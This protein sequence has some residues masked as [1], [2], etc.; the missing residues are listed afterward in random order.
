MYTMTLDMPRVREL[1]T[2][3]HNESLMRTGRRTEALKL[4]LGKCNVLVCMC[5]VL[6]VYV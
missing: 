2:V 1:L 4:L 3:T 6:C 5:S